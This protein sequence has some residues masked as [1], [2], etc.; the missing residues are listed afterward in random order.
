ML[1]PPIRPPM[2]SSYAALVGGIAQPS[3]FHDGSCSSLPLPQRPRWVDQ[4]GRCSL[5]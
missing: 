2:L 4:F 3:G 1:L 5:A